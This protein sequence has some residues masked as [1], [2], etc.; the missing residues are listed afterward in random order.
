M[1]AVARG[2]THKETENKEMDV[3]LAMAIVKEIGKTFEKLHNESI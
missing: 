1:G 3:V 2:W